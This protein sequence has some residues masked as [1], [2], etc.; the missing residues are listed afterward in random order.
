MAYWLNF[1]GGPLDGHRSLWAT[2]PPKY[3]RC[4][5]PLYTDYSSDVKMAD[6]GEGKAWIDVETVE[7]FL[8]SRVDNQYYYELTFSE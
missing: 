4:P 7:Y 3:Y 8:V 2:Q 6:S 1:K 5:A